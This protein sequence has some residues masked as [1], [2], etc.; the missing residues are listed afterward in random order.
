MM[1]STG[2]PPNVRRNADG[3]PRKNA[4]GSYRLNVRK[5]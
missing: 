1:M 4:D 3:T 5:T 2:I